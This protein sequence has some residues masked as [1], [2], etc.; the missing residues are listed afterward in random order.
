M[1]LRPGAA[2]AR[3]QQGERGNR[4]G[5]DDGGGQP[6]IRPERAAPLDSELS[7]RFAATATPAGRRRTG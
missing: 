4:Q 5:E 7:E 1:G 6:A 2:R 3:E